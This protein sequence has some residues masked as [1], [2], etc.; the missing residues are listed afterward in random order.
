MGSTFTPKASLSKKDMDD[1]SKDFISALHDSV[2]CQ[3]L[4]NLSTKEA[5]STSILARRWRYLFAYVPDLDF[6]DSSSL[7]PTSF[8]KFVDRVLELGKDCVLNKFSLKSGKDIWGWGSKVSSWISKVLERGVSDL[9][10]HFSPEIYSPLP[11][12]IFKSKSLVRLKIG[13]EGGPSRQLKK[14]CLPKLKT[15][16]LDSFMFEEDA[17]GFPKLLSGCPV[18]EELGLPNLRWGY[19][20]SCSVSSKTLKRLILCSFK[21]L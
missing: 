9:D 8:A 16:H 7:D 4:S 19:W 15:L 11:S 6:D 10:L 2:L 5:G 18:L 1:C 12:K 21:L 20:E 17:M 13:P 14:V 3:I